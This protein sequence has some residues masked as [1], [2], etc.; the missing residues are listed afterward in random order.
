MEPHSL[1][2]MAGLIPKF[3]K[4]EIEVINTVYWILSNTIAGLAGIRKSF[5][6]MCRGQVPQ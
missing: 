6:Q 5:Q 2:Q 1:L 4:L 3:H